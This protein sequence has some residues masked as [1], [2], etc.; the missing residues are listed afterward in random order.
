MLGNVRVSHY[1]SKFGGMMQRTMKQITLSNAQAQ[2]MF[3]FSDL[4]RATVLL[5]YERLVYFFYTPV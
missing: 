3:T 5:F 2:P 4:S 1:G